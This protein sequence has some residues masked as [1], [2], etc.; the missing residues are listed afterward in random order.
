MCALVC[1]IVATKTYK[2]FKMYF[3]NPDWRGCV[4]GR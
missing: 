3:N 4:S 1:Q 2:N